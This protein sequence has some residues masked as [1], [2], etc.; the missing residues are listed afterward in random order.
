MPYIDTPNQHLFCVRRASGRSDAPR[1]LFIHG[2]GGNALLWGRV[3]NCLPDADCLALD[4]PAHGRSSGGPS[5]DLSTYTS[6]VLELVQALEL[7][8]LV[9]AG[10]SMGGAIA[11][12]VAL[13][14]PGRVRALILIST[15]AR[16]LVS[17]AL[18]EQLAADPAAARQWIVE[19]GYGPQTLAQTRRLGIQQLAQV[20]PEV[21][22]GD[23]L[24]CSNVDL[25]P[26]LP[27]IACPALVLC[28]SEDRLV[29]LKYARALQEGLPQARFQLIPAAGHMLPLEAPEAVA[30]AIS[31]FLAALPPL[32]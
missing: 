17:P 15:T 31:A 9:I 23:F 29:S 11:L 2:A 4:L 28:G 18:L 6:A 14:D 5:S 26:R 22:R 16:L 7:R 21:L 27:E 10:H 30:E 32:R 1:V 13:H 25:R 8:S 20:A 12:A 24:A 19:T 3:L